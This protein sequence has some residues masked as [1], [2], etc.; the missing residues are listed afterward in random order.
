MKNG[1]NRWALK[2]AAL[3]SV[4]FV[5]LPAAAQTTTAT[6]A[7]GP[8]KPMYG[9]LRPFYGNLRAFSGDVTPYYGNIRAFYGNLRPFYGN[10][11][12]FWGN[13]APF[14]GDV[15]PYAGDVT[16]FW[17]NLRAF[18]GGVT[19]T[20]V[21]TFW[22]QAG[23]RW[24]GIATSWAVADQV[25][26]SLAY[27][28]VA[29]QLQGLVDSSKSYW[30]PAI[31]AQTGKTF[32]AGFANPLLAKYGIDL[33]DASSLAKL[34]DSDRAMFF[35][36]WYD[37][38]MNFTGGD[39]VDHWMKTINWTPQLTQT[40]GYGKDTVIGLLDFTVTGDTVIQQN[41]VKYDGVSN[42]TNGHGAAVASLM[43]GAHDGKGV[44]GIAPKAS[45]IAY[46]PFDATGT[47]NWDDIKKGVLM[48]AQN[49]ASII[50]MSLGV[51]G[52]TLDQGWNAVFSDP[53]VAVATKN[54]LFVVAAGN[55]GT[56]QT[57]NI[58]WNFTTNPN[59]I[60]VGSIDLAGNISNFSNTPGT[61]CLLDAG[62]CKAGNRL[63]DHF[64]VAPGELIL[65]SDDKGGVTRM[66]GTSFAAPLVSGAVALLQDRW[67][68]LA[69]YPKET[70]DIILKSAKDLGAPG[71]D[72]VYGVGLLDVTA[73]QSPLNFSA[74]KWY[75]ADDKGKLKEE[76]VSK[77]VSTAASEKQAKWDAKGVYFYAFETVG[78]T[79]RD[80]AIPLSQKLVGQ[81]VTT[82]NG[83]QEMFQAYL[84]SR[85]DSWV[86][87]QT[88]TK[89]AGPSAGF[90]S[91]AKVPNAWGLD[92]TLSVATRTA[93]Y[94]FR[95]DG[96]GYQSKLSIAGEHTT[97]QFGFGDGAVALSGQN[98]LA[99][100]GD[101]DSDYGGANPVLGL[102]SGGVFANWTYTVGERLSLSAGATQ[103]DMVRDRSNLPGLDFA[104]T[105]AERYTASAQHLG[106]RYAVNGRVDV[107]SAYTR[108]HERSAVLGLQ[109]LAADDFHGGSTTDGMTVGLD[110]DLGQGLTLGLSGTLAKTRTDAS[111]GLRTSSQG[112][113]STAFEVALS[114]ADLFTAGDV[115]RFTLSQPLTVTRGA[116][117]MN[118][119]QVI[120]RSTGEIGVVAQR[121]DVSQARPFAGELLYGRSLLGG[122]SD[123]SLFGRVQLDPAS[124]GPAQ[125][126]M[127]G[128]RIRLAF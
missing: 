87:S 89:F 115:A 61:A 93:R 38:L 26:V 122:K 97:T 125:T 79:T 86:T 40:Q 37:G 95:Q 1:R 33:N 107:T 106:A 42:F 99:T 98:A 119:V 108:L 24:D 70:A 76:T 5:A 19:A 44:M 71:V 60:V 68:W 45:V 7:A 63:M 54:T 94:G 48:L 47:A 73:S 83:G 13:V 74:L 22:T 82:A 65:V 25:G 34:D 36:D 81:N 110:A 3:A 124:A 29:A 39:H 35:L 50:N 41:I 66:S 96:P 90:F 127:A 46:N 104:D 126:Y 78:A 72:P 4:S 59:L 27:A 69:N 6:V 55:E 15:G 109:S 111:A 118:S 17:G 91:E 53:S 123:V 20:G 77:V 2:L 52:S 92:M 9:N 30:S 103:R 43:V 101:Y 14:W 18:S 114:K 102:A 32:E 128:G 57:Q 112:L 28:P 12:P 16:A 31:T 8:V 23:V 75:S 67:P 80:F 21:N 58:N 88:K 11:R 117:A 105:G 84:L 121:F 100:A 85:M 51:P 49:K 113:T 62:V 10:L 116:L 120:D 64:I 56:V